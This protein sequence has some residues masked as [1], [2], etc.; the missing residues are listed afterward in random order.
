MDNFKKQ[1]AMKSVD[2]VFENMDKQ[3]PIIKKQYDFL[4]ETTDLFV[5]YYE[6]SNIRS[7]PSS[8]NCLR[9][10]SSE[11]SLVFSSAAS[12]RNIIDES[13]KEK[14]KNKEPY[15]YVTQKSPY[16]FEHIFCESTEYK[17]R[18]ITYS[19]VRQEE[20]LG[21]KPVTIERVKNNTLYDALNC[22]K[23]PTF[24]EQLI[25]SI[26]SSE[27]YKKYITNEE[28]QQLKDKLP[29]LQENLSMD[30]DYEKE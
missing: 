28:L 27:F 15:S 6:S 5:Q 30:E 19:Y 24:L 12:Y 1:L 4:M 29:M 22:I 16:G 3:N 25:E 9:N 7:I 26:Q 11:N 21:R 18:G 2:N 13:I 14:I 17:N 23:T 10:D 8:Y 20:N